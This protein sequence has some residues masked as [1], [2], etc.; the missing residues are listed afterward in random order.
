MPSAIGIDLGTTRSAVAVY[1]NEE[2]IVIPQEDGKFMPSVVSFSE[3]EVLVGN[4]AK[5]EAVV[6]PENTIF[7]EK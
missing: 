2:V 4:L 5:E 6:N 3:K 7:G 1:M